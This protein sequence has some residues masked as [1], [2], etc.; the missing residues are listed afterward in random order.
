MP[1]RILVVD[2]EEYVALTLSALL[3]REGYQTCSALRLDDALARL[4][5]DR[6]EAVLLDLMLAGEDGLQVL[7]RQREPD[8]SPGA[9][10]AGWGW[11]IAE[12]AGI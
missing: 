6:F 3:D 1:E 7:A 10:R 5:S 2:D 12:L 11:L 9:E 8:Q 4:G